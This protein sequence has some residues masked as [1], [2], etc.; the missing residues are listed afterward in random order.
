MGG[1]PFLQG[2]SVWSQPN[3]GITPIGYMARGVKGEVNM[4]NSAINN[5]QRITGTCLSLSPVFNAQLTL[6]F[7]CTWTE[8]RHFRLVDIITI[9]G[10]DAGYEIKRGSH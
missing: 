10:V 8:C 7:G 3:Q 4:V 9:N 1:T 6:F 5:G 2:F